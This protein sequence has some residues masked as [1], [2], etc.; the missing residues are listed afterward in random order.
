MKAASEI[1]QD[2]TFIGTIQPTQLC[3]LHKPCAN[4]RRCQN[5]PTQPVL[6]FDKIAKQWR[7]DRKEKS[8]PSVDA[9]TCKDEELYFVEIKGW[10]Q[11][12]R[13]QQLSEESIKQ[14]AEAYDLQGKLIRSVE[15]CE[16]VTG[17]RNILTNIPSVF[18][19]VTDIDVEKQGFESIV[20]N[21]NLLGRTTSEW[22]TVCNFY[23]GE[24]LNSI[25]QIRTRYVA[26]AE[27]DS[28]FFSVPP[29][30]L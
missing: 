10:K 28:L 17:E 12:L 15:L 2:L 30:V 24:R 16:E 19:L 11:F 8:T 21:L 5:S 7:K 1:Y 20:H 25:R 9:L 29:A 14:Q 27:F 3:T 6:D 18:V 23:L 13:H 26:C 4:E 22:E